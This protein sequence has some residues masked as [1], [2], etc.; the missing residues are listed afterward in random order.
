MPTTH[1]QQHVDNQ[2]YI[3][4]KDEQSHHSNSQD[5]ERDKCVDD[6]QL[7]P[8]SLDTA[9]VLLAVRGSARKFNPIFHQSTFS[10]WEM[11]SPYFLLHTPL[12]LLM[13]CNW[14]Q[15]PLLWLFCWAVGSA[16]GSASVLEDVMH[17]HTPLS[18]V[19]SQQL[20]CLAPAGENTLYTTA[21]PYCFAI[22]QQIRCH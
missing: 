18:G 21:T 20:L 7:A 16:V 5:P 8:L 11:N 1:S 14:L 10:T 6:K 9:E 15:T 3:Y 12:L 13:H 2:R 17:T 19:S 22:K 4:I